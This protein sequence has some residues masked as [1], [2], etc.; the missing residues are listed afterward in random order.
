MERRGLP[1]RSGDAAPVLLLKN[2]L[3]RPT[4][5][6]DGC[7]SRR[8]DSSSLMSAILLVCAALILAHLAASVLRR[9]AA[10]ALAFSAAAVILGLTNDLALAGACACVALVAAAAAFD[11]AAKSR[12]RLAYWIECVL[13]G[14]FGLWLVFITCHGVKDRWFLALAAVALAAICSALVADRRSNLHTQR[15]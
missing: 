2:A 1:V 5:A 6:L 9:A 8:E 12:V 10:F 13:A 3:V 11:V 15:L 4:V 7:S 14:A